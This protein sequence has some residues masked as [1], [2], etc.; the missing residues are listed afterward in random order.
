MAIWE[1]TKKRHIWVVLFYSQNSL[2]ATGSA[3]VTSRRTA[4]WLA[5]KHAEKDAGN[6][7]VWCSFYFFFSKRTYPGEKTYSV[8]S[9][10]VG[11][12]AIRCRADGSATKAVA[13]ITFYLEGRKRKW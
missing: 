13:G 4:K 6:S 2:A 11:A 1:R 3:R 8:P 7:A 5:R 12:D 10:Q 9:L